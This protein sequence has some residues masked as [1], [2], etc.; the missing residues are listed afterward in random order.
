MRRERTRGGTL[1]SASLLLA[2]C[3]GANLAETNAAC[4]RMTEVVAAFAG[5]P[6][7]LET[8]DELTLGDIESSFD[9]AQA[10]FAIHRTISE[11]IP[12]DTPVSNPSVAQRLKSACPDAYARYWDRWTALSRKAHA[13]RQQDQ[14]EPEPSP[15]ATRRPR[16]DTQRVSRSDLGSAWPLTVDSGV[17]V[18][19]REGRRIIASFLVDGTSNEYALNASAERQGFPPIDPIWADD[20]RYASSGAGIKIAITPLRSRALEL[21]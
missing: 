7:S 19:S 14:G 17:L 10:N 18:C 21:C 16:F 3:S 12:L 1:I 6:T 9:V 2:A 20:P 5:K 15:P 4:E 13:E 11:S 8:F